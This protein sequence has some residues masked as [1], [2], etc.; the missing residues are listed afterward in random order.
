MLGLWAVVEAWLLQALGEQPVS[1]EQANAPVTATQVDLETLDLL[2]YLVASEHPVLIEAY[3]QLEA[4]LEH[5]MAQQTQG[6]EDRVRALGLQR[7]A[8]SDFWDTAHSLLAPLHSNPKALSSCLPSQQERLQQCLDQLVEEQRDLDSQ[9]AAAG[10]AATTPDRLGSTNLRYLR[11][12]AANGDEVVV[13]AHRRFMATDNWDSFTCELLVFANRWTRRDVQTEQLVEYSRLLHQRGLVT[14]V[15]LDWLLDALYSKEPEPLLRGVA[16]LEAGLSDLLQAAAQEEAAAELAQ[17]GGRG[18]P[19]GPA[20]A[21]LAA[22]RVQAYQ[23]LFQR[24]EK[25]LEGRARA[26][27]DAA[28]KGLEQAVAHAVRNEHKPSDEKHPN[29]SDG[30]EDKKQ[31]GVMS[32]HHL[33]LVALQSLADLR[34]RRDV[35]LF[36]AYAD[37]QERGDRAEFAETIRT[38]SRRRWRRD[39]MTQKPA[40]HGIFTPVGELVERGMISPQEDLELIELLVY[41]RNPSLST[42]YEALHS[43]GSERDRETAMNKFVLCVLDLLR[44]AKQEQQE[45]LLKELEKLLVSLRREGKLSEVQALHLKKLS[46]SRDESLLEVLRVG[47][48]DGHSSSDNPQPTLLSKLQELGS[49]WTGHGTLQQ[50]L[51]R[52]LQ[53]W[54]EE[55]RLPDFLVSE[56]ELLL[57]SRDPLVY[58]L[59]K[60]Y[61][62]HLERAAKIAAATHQDEEAKRKAVEEDLEIFWIGVWGVCAQ[63]RVLA[64]NSA[65]KNL[66][67][68]V[69]EMYRAKRLRRAG[70]SYLRHVVT[71]AELPP[72]VQKEYVTWMKQG[73]L[74]PLEEILYNTSF[75]W[76]VMVPALHGRILTTL[77]HLETHKRLSEEEYG[78]LEH[79]V[80]MQ[81][82]A[83]LGAFT[84]LEKAGSTAATA[85]RFEASLKEIVRQHKLSSKPSSGS[86]TAVNSPDK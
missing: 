32:S 29:P 44:S 55:R 54:R 19:T 68:V 83:V 79:L 26:E 67:R 85:S 70:C 17:R 53:A 36:A 57:Y 37:L 22:A 63:T 42:A 46:E 65:A 60:S 59:K 6:D 9:A 49:L 18:A 40:L 84:E 2:Q 30:L 31:G 3:R 58:S 62:L 11:E 80:Y 39:L 50:G 15:E 20:G 5:I 35:V 38:L 41:H 78:Y 52:I 8:F 23:R 76:Q 48:R 16:E 10:G 66:D 24:V 69:R 27:M 7:L 71:W 74:K 1:E 12:L 21:A 51:H 47:H 64:G 45:L 82:P 34:E 33:S 13:Q 73:E 86:S 72:P 14:A 43:A 4:Q 61:S 56:L 28:A 77:K 81:H 25:W 75:R